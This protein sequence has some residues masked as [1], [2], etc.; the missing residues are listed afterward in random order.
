MAADTPHESRGS[1]ALAG[2]FVERGEQAEM[3]RRA[4]IHAV[5]LYRIAAGKALPRG[6]EAARLVVEGIPVHW[7][8]EDPL[9]EQLP[10]SQKPAEPAA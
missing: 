9:P 7:W 4:K 6:D 8:D 10:D 3:A 1:R 5:R 2:K